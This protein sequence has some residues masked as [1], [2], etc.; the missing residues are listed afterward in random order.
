M[1]RVEIKN[2]AKSMIKGKLE[3]VWKAYFVVLLISLGAGLVMGLLTGD[4]TESSF[5]A[6]INIIISLALMPISVG[7]MVYML[8]FVRNQNPETKDVWSTFSK[9]IPII[10]TSI[11]AAFAI[12]LGFILLIIPGIILSLGLSMYVYILADSNYNLS[13][14]EVLRES[15]RLMKGYKGEY[16]VFNLSF[17]GWMFLV[18]LTF[19]LLLIWLLPYILTAETLFYERLKSAP[20]IQ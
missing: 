11:I 1:N 3:I 12:S 8:K 4:N 10:L 15:W 7:I 2:Q 5:Y 6:L 20:R 16:F 18:P 14:V 9:F 17:I 19:G 13:P